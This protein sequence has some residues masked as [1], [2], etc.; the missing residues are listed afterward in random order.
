MLCVVSGC[1]TT[2]TH[3]HTLA[4]AIWNFIDDQQ[5]KPLH[6]AAPTSQD[7]GNILSPV[8]R[9]DER[10]ATGEEKAQKP[11][12]LAFLQPCPVCNGVDFAMNEARKLVC[13]TCFPSG[14]GLKVRPAPQKRPVESQK[15]G[16]FDLI[17]QDTEDAT[18]AQREQCFQSAVPWIEKHLPELLKTGWT[19]EELFGKCSQAWPYGGWGV[20]WLPVW[21]KKHLTVSTNQHTGAI[22][23]HFSG[24]DGRPVTQTA[25][26]RKPQKG[27]RK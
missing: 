15:E 9:P 18:A 4:M 2:V 10:P 11:V 3:C 7:D 25:H 8:Q 5:G 16:E 23:F 22:C 17:E 14:S 26:P 1:H 27:Q 24:T 6:K 13:T 20:A 21:L 12:E 19:R